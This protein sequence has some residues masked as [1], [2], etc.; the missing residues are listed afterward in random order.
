MGRK[1]GGRRKVH[2]SRYGK[3]RRKE[4]E[5]IRREGRP[6]RKEGEALRREGRSRRKEG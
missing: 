1:G 6:R 2:V 4:G 5:D 3:P